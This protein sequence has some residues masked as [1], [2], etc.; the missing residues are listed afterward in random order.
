[1]NV[2]FRSFN[3]ERDLERLFEYMIDEKNQVNFSHSFQIHNI[4]MF[5]K[6]ITLKFANNEF[7]D[8]FMIE[9]GKGNA[10]GFTYSYDYYS[11]DL[12]CKYTLCL[13]EEYQNLGYG[14]IAGVKMMLYLFDK[15]PLNRIYIS[16]FDYNKN[17][18][19]NNLKGGFTEVGV[20]PEYRYYG[21]ERFS[22]HILTMERKTFFA[23]HKKIITRLQNSKNN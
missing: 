22:L 16:I 9:D 19:N 21:G 13:Y 1:M 11:C 12:H 10:I 23:R 6:W 18:L 20:L 2:R 14:A 8:F 5:E 3:Y 7:H 4:L 17:S 15:Y